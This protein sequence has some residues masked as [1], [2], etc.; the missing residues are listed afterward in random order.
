[1]LAVN[2]KCPRQIAIFFSGFTFVVDAYLCRS[3]C[4][5]HRS[6]LSVLFQVGLLLGSFVLDLPW[7]GLPEH[8]PGRTALAAGYYVPDVG[9]QTPQQCSAG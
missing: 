7:R 4:S 1:M 2:T 9:Y 5:R 6:L 3:W 8:W